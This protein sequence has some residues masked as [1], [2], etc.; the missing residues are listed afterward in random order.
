M[1]KSQH[2]LVSP[3]WLSPGWLVTRNVEC[4]NAF[5]SEFTAGKESRQVHLKNL[6]FFKKNHNIIGA[7][8][9]DLH[10]SLLYEFR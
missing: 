3:S 5:G 10:L 1:Q 2:Q 7:Y 4:R 6:Q 9:R 8:L